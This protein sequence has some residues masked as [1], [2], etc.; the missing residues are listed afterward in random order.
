MT[1]SAMH[2]LNMDVA[3][4]YLLMAATLAY[5]KSRELLPPEAQTVLE[6]EEG[7]EGGA[8]R[9]AREPDSA[10]PEY[11]KFKGRRGAVR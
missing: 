10:P 2:A 1:L 7:E 5:I 3:S 6:A 4:E 9:S 11:Q 8:R